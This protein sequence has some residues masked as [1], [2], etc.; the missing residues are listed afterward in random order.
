MS[1]L[2][3]ELKET[4]L[5]TMISV[6]KLHVKRPF[7]EGRV[8]VDI[9]QYWLLSKISEKSLSIQDMANLAK[10]S[11]HIVL[12][13]LSYLQK[14]DLITK[15]RTDGREV[16]LDL[17]PFGAEFLEKVHSQYESLLGFSEGKYSIKEERTI[18]AYLNELNN[19]IES[20]I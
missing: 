12:S 15:E 11:R 4:L 7:G 17:S 9:F 13:N 3:N 20:N 16:E 8:R 2:K 18:V 19:S 5:R 14:S 10:V 1:T 6:H